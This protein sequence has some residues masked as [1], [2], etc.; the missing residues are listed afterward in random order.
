M[1][2]LISSL[3]RQTGIVGRLSLASSVAR[4]YYHRYASMTA[5]TTPLVTRSISPLGKSIIAN[6]WQSAYL[7]RPLQG[8]NC[9]ECTI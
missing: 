7:L 2:L 4:H 1:R 6:R 3:T 9:N 8:N 5:T